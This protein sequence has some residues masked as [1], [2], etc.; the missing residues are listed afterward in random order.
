MPP[1]FNLKHMKK[2]I[3]IMKLKEKKLKILD[4]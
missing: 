1:S 3:M 4:I 2:K